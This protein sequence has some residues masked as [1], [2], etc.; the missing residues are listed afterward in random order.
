VKFDE[1]GACPRVAA[2]CGTG[3][4]GGYLV[5]VVDVFRTL[6]TV[7]AGTEA[8][9]LRSVLRLPRRVLRRVVGRPVTIDGQTLDPEMQATLRLQK[10]AKIPRIETLPLPAGRALLRDQ[11]QI[12]CGEQPI[13]ESRELQ[14]PGADGDRPA[15]LYVPRGT[16]GPSALL[17]FIPGGAWVYGDLESH[18]GI[19]RYL[20]ERSGVRVLSL[21]YR[22]APEH[23]YPAGLDDC[24][25]AYTWVRDNA[26]SLGADPARIAVGGDSA[27][28]NLSI[29]VCLRARDEGVPQPAAQMLVYPVTDFSQRLPSRSMFGEGF[30]LSTEFMDRC[31]AAYVS[32]G[33]DP[34]DPLL[35]PL[36]AKDLSGL[37]PAYVATAGFD[38]LRDEGEAFARR[39]G[40]DGGT[41]ALTRHPGLIH[42]FFNMVGV[43]RSARAAV[44]ELVLQLRDL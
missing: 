30:Y 11:S 24:W 18:D 3:E 27:G 29:G 38:P 37:A 43:S 41:V 35:S 32:E 15:R 2:P 12:V 31:E 9:T 14:V 1:P 6:D 33:A 5:D 36:Q 22:K 21:D 39:I 23:P 42:G 4:A 19:C 8:A 13:G 10:A 17:F 16:T 44:D 20:A 7:R 28:G 25:A 40:D 34:T 26:G